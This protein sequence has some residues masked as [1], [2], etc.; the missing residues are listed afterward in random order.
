MKIS[1]ALFGLSSASPA[2]LKA[3]AK[4]PTYETSQ[5]YSATSTSYGYGK[6]I[7]CWHCHSYSFEEC[8]R[9]GHQRKCHASEV[10]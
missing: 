10:S 6:G 8:Q 4:N 3:E 2:A 5:T 1:L 7:S 9:K